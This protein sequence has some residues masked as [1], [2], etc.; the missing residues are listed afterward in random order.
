[1]SIAPPVMHALPPKPVMA[2]SALALSRSSDAKDGKPKSSAT[3]NGADANLKNNSTD[4]DCDPDDRDLRQSSSSR[5]LWNVRRLV[6]NNANASAYDART[7]DTPTAID[8]PTVTDALTATDAPTSTDVPTTTIATGCQRTHTRGC[9]IAATTHVHAE[10]Q[11][12]GAA[13][14]NEDMSYQDRHYRPGD[15]LA[16]GRTSTSCEQQQRDPQPA[17]HREQRD[18]QPRPI[19]SADGAANQNEDMSYQDRHYRPG[20]HLASGRTSTSCEQQQRDPQPAI[21]REQRDSQPRPIMSAP[22]TLTLHPKPTSLLLRRP[23]HS[24]FLF[25]AY[26]HWG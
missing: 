20:D 22:S 18:S 11:L 17:I 23:R 3:S 7:T 26:W 19:M 9:N 24:L 6:T 4:R 5:N 25:R 16:S 13:N 14:Q 21:H 2:V 8:I 10:Q 12:D 15:H 1:M